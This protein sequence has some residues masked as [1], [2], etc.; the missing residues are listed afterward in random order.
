MPKHAFKRL[1]R[2]LKIF[3]NT[4]ITKLISARALL[5]SIAATDKWISPK[6]SY[7][8][9]ACRWHWQWILPSYSSFTQALQCVSPC[10]LVLA[11]FLFPKN[12]H[13]TFVRLTCK[14]TQR[15]RATTPNIVGCYMLCPIALLVACCCVLLGVV[16]RTLKLVKLLSQ[17]LFCSLITEA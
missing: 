8:V 9:G 3:V 10:L 5:R 15:C 6:F 2:E 14:R 12:L 16:S 1:Y 4:V 13:T 11:R 7:L 17:H